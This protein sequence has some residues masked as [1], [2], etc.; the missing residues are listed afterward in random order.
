MSSNMRAELFGTVKYLPI[1]VYIA[2]TH[3]TTNSQTEEY[4]Y[5]EWDFG[6]RE[7]DEQGKERY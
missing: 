5:V 7:C 4:Q 1:Y 6:I 3:S 2:N